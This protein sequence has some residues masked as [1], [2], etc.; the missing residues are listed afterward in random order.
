MT[1]EVAAGT[2]DSSAT[3]GTGTVRFDDFDNRP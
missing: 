1:V 2:Y 3:I